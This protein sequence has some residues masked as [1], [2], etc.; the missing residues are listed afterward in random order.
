VTNNA[1]AVDVSSNHVTGNVQVNNNSPGGATILNNSTGKC[2]QNHNQPFTGSG[3]TGTR[4]DSCNGIV[5]PPKMVTCSGILAA[6]TYHDVSVGIGQSCT[7]TSANVIQHDLTLSSGST[8]N[9]SG[10]SIGHDIHATGASAVSVSGGSVVHHLNVTNTSGAVSLT[11][12][13][14]SDDVNVNGGAGAVTVTGN[15][16]SHNV[17]VTNNAPGGATV[18]G[19]SDKQCKQSNNH[20]YLGSTNNAPGNCNG[21]NA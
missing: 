18:Q 8:L 9:D 5:P 11:G 12:I 20:P 17:N 15:T 13:T 16:V 21:S 7:L 3:N 14:V 10:A 19:N 4:V 6:G 2:S 1:G